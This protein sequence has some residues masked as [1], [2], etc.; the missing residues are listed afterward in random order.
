MARGDR[1]EIEHA[2]EPDRLRQIIAEL[3]SELA[4][5]KHAEELLQRFFATSLDMLCIANFEGIYT[6][7]NRAWERALGYT[8]DELG[9]HPFIFFVHPDDHAA[10]LAELKK[11]SEGADTISFENR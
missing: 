4:N 7:L 1:L 2:V 6:R 8:A 9:V 3:R 11:L 10:T 5:A